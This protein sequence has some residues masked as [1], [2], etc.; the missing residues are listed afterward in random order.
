MIIVVSDVHMGYEGSDIASFEN[1]VYDYV[2]KKL[3]SNDY[4]VLLGDIFDFWRRKN[5]DSMLENK[6]VLQMA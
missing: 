4:F 1:F 2:S 3:G 6:K 5:M